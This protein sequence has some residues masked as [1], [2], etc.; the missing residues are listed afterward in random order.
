MESLDFEF[1]NPKEHSNKDCPWFAS[2]G[3]SKV[4]KVESQVKVVE[5]VTYTV[6][7]PKNKTRQNSKSK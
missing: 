5:S 2:V 3:S 4:D 6:I 7:L 1:E